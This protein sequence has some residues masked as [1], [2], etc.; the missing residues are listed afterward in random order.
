MIILD[1]ATI[2]STSLNFPI[3]RF[4]SARIEC[5]NVVVFVNGSLEMKLRLK[6]RFAYG[7]T[8]IQNLFNQ[9]QFST[10]CLKNIGKTNICKHSNENHLQIKH[11]SSSTNIEAKD[12]NKQNK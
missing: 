3:S 12:K 1:K 7:K 2:Y 10:K 11:S 4:M 8:W 5:W 9:S 6:T